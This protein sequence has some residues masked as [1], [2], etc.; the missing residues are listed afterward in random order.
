MKIACLHTHEGNVAMFEQAAAALGLPD[1]TLHHEVRP[2]LLRAAEDAGGLTPAIADETGAI[3][4]ELGRDADAVLLTCST[5]GQAAATA[6]P[7]APVPILRA[8]GALA[9]RATGAGGAVAVLCA[10]ETTVVPTTRLFAEAAARSGA[11]LDIRLV[12]GA[13]AL[14][15]AGDRDG[16]LRAIARAADEAYGDGASIVALA[17]ASMTDAAALVTRGPRPLSSPAAGLAAAVERIG[18][19]SPQAV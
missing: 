13:W 14:F 15:R 19:A 2:E 9:E 5:L 7:A 6:A 12:P 10:L 3:L 18:A 17:Q 1:G 8:D 4:L 11:R 16:Y